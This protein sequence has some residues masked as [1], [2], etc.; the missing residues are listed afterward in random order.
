M[1]ITRRAEDYF[2]L[3]RAAM[4]ACGVDEFRVEERD[5]RLFLVSVMVDGSEGPS[6]DFTNAPSVWRD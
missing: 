5:G 1:K 4:L 2:E 3:D 6:V